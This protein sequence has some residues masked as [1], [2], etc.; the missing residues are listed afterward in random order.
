MSDKGSRSAGG[1]QVVV[2]IGNDWVKMAQVDAVRGGVNISRLYLQRFESLDESVSES[3]AEASSKLKFA[4]IPVIACLPRQMVNIRML[5]LPST[6]PLE[7][8][9]MVDLQIGKQTPYSK[10]EI[11]SDYRILGS[12]RE[13]YSR[14]MLAIVQ[15]NILRHRFRLLEEAGLDVGR[16]TVSSE[17][18]LSWSN[19]AV[20]MP[21]EG[22]CAVLDIDSFYCDFAVIADGRLAFTRSILVGADQLLSDP[23]RWKP[24]VL[25]EVRRSLDIYRGD[26]GGLDVGKLVLTGA[27]A[28]IDGLAVD[29][30]DHVGL[31]VEGVDSLDSVKKAPPS[32]DLRAEE[33]RGLSL[34]G[35]VGAGMAPGDLQF[36]LVPETV[37]L[38][39]ALVTKSRSLSACATLIITAAVMASLLAAI[40]VRLLSHRLDAVRKGIEETEPKVRETGWKSDTVKLVRSRQDLRFAAIN[41]MQDI[42]RNVPEGVRFDTVEMNLPAKRLVLGGVGK[43]RRDISTLIKNLE[44]SPLF[45]KVGE[46]GPTTVDTR[47]GE[48]R[49]QVVCTLEDAG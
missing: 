16:M 35:L 24:K 48:Y 33:Y 9:D 39:K 43:L 4:G 17:G 10:D 7:V 1:T 34:T 41:V 44:R 49:F 26:S 2:E 31:P 11:V 32:P 12:Q 15:R 46:G 5:E 40:K 38:R 27:G 28:G 37:T 23:G 36:N 47:T 14:V 8:A 6:D 18:L 21:A 20:A 25:E 45:E 29:L 3:I 30:G 22:G 19:A 13:G 42:H